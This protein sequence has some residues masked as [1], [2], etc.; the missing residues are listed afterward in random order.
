MY[1]SKYLYSWL[2]SRIDPETWKFSTSIL[3]TVGVWSF[4]P[5]YCR[6]VVI[7][8]FILENKFSLGNPGKFNAS[9]KQ[10]AVIRYLQELESQAAIFSRSYMYMYT[11]GVLIEAYMSH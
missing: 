3:S 9:K 8:T 7:W 6:G 11:D 2:F 4:E 1:L 10:P 5:L